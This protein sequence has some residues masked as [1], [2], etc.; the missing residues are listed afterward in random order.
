VEILILSSLGTKPSKR[1]LFARTNGGV[2]VWNGKVY[3]GTGDCRLVAIDAT[4]AKKVW[5]ATVCEPT[6]TGITGHRMSR[7]EES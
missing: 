1:F 2:A 6:Q 7:R 4:T 3:V 5:E